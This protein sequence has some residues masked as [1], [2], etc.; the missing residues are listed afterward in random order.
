MRWLSNTSIRKR[1]LLIIMAISSISV[2]TAATSITYLGIHD[3]KQNLAKNM[4]VT[5]SVMGERNKAAILFY[6]QLDAVDNL[7]AFRASPS[8]VRAC[9]YDKYGDFFAGYSLSDNPDIAN[10]CS[11]LSQKKAGFYIGSLITDKEI[12]DEDGRVGVIYI[13][14]DLK[15]ISDSIESRIYATLAFVLA[16]MALSYYMALHLQRSIST[17][18]LKLTDTARAVSEHKDYSVRAEKLD[19]HNSAS[20]NELVT[21]IDSVNTMLVEIEERDR[22]LLQHTEALRIAKEEAESAN[23]AKSHF[24]ANIS[25]ELRTPLNAIIGFSSII[26][27]QL[28]GTLG[29]EKYLEY[30]NDINESGVHLLNIIND[31]LD[32]SKA[33]AGKLALTVEEVNVAKAINKCVTIIAERAA[34]G[35]ITLEK[36][37]PRDLPYC[38]V[39]RLRFIQIVLNIVSNAVKFTEEGGKVTIEAVGH[40]DKENLEGFSVIVTDTGIGM[41]QEDIDKAF[42]SFV[43]VDSDLNRRYE[44]T[45]LGLPLTKMLVDLHE[46]ELKI[47]SEVGK[48]T[49]VEIQFKND[50]KKL[51]DMHEKGEA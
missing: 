43:Q 36:H 27:N 25:H 37:L 3:L 7:A 34:E 40:G 17:P 20:N 19:H 10:E 15:E 9:I 39:D 6:S 49:R 44:G 4:A 14:S 50:L 16:V 47:E 11:E 32:L 48:G 42:Q 18:I 29:N 31:I 1:L 13:E 38:Y 12:V 51:M 21:L 45:G 46:G 26:I 8:V 24:L 30:A 5:A 22:R 33:E 2:L 23:R 41:N 28:F 35:G